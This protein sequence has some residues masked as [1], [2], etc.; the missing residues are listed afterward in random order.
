M[1]ANTRIAGLF[2]FLISFIL[3]LSLSV[4][5]ETS[6]CTYRLRCAG[7]RPCR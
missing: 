7:F 5:A 2:L 3:F 6:E 1:N 4:R